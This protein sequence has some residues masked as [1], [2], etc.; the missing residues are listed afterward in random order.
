MTY[1]DGAYLPDDL[2]LLSEDEQEKS[3]VY[4]ML[5][6]YQSS[7][8]ELRS[9]EE[10]DLE[11]VSAAADRLISDLDNGGY[12]LIFN[13]A[14]ETPYDPDLCFGQIGVEWR[15]GQTAFIAMPGIKKGDKVIWKATVWSPE[16]KDHPYYEQIKFLGDVINM[17]R[18]KA[19]GQSL[20]R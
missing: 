7:V 12:E 6:D 15:K 16:N 10:P 20:V 1:D 5:E 13:Y 11:T 17:K 8:S 18:N 9:T 14:Q 19:S 4:Q 2:P 3:V